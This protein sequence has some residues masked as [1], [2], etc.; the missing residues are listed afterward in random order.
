MSSKGDYSFQLI[1]AY[2]D[3]NRNTRR[4]KW[5]KLGMIGSLIGGDAWILGGD[6]NKIWKSVNVREMEFSI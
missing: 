1:V 6:F 2:G 5:T 4:Q 3:N